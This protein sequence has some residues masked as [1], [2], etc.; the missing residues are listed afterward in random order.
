M[1]KNI[2]INER[3]HE[4]PVFVYVRTK[5]YI[6]HVYMSCAATAKLI[7]AFDFTIRI[8]QSLFYFSPRCQAIMHI[9]WL[10]RPVRVEPCRKPRQSIFS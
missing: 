1:K 10:Q 3:R 9:L 8:E 2:Y 6:V 5:T 4:R 7:S